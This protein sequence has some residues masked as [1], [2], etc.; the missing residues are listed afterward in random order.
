MAS[1][2]S[3]GG[4]S[5]GLSNLASILDR[6]GSAVKLISDGWNSVAKLFNVTGEGGILSGFNP[7]RT[8]S[9][10]SKEAK[11]ENPMDKYAKQ[12]AKIEADRKKQN[13]AVLKSQKALTAEQKKQAMA[14]KQSALF[15]LEQ[16]GIIA[17]LKGDISEEERLRLNLQLALLT[18]NDAMATKLSAQLA[19]S[20]D[21]TGNLARYL[22]TL[23]E[24]NNPFKNFESY[25]DAIYKNWSSKDWSIPVGNGSPTPSLF[26]SEALSTP[27][28]GFN[29]AGISEGDVYITVQGSVVSQEDLENMVLTG[30]QGKALSGSPSVIG[31]I[32][33]MFG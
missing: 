20:I 13:A 8:S 24:A 32:S 15:D 11:P 5:K 6:I 22:A 28:G 26:S 3:S 30:L 29:T 21:Q 23:P 33:G 7:Y 10:S 4:Q 17:A 19:N 1:F 18:G 31:R 14:K 9:S 12:L 16:I 25:L 2:G 27:Y